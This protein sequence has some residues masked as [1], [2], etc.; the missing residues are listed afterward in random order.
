M[1]LSEVIE[2]S[3]NNAVDQNSKVL[4]K[5][6]L[7]SSQLANFVEETGLIINNTVS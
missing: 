1:M 7:Y 6:A 2:L 5:V 3:E 4:R